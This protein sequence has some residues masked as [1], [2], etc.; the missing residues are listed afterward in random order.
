MENKN[1]LSTGNSIPFGM[2]DLFKYYSACTLSFSNSN[3]P[4]PYPKRSEQL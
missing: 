4:E 2:Y 3:I 1:S